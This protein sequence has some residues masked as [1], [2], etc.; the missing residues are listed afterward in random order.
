LPSV[1]ADNPLR[2]IFIAGTDTGVGKTH[3]ACALLR[4]ARNLGH[5]P[6][7][8]KP[9][10]TGA[11]PTPDDADRL[12]EAAGPS[13]PRGE[14]CLYPLPL[15]AAPQAAAEAASVTISA[16][17]ILAHAHR[18]ATAGDSLV[19]EAAGGLLVPYHPTLTGADLARLLGLPVLLVARTSLG[20]V[21]HTALTVN[22]I[23]RRG[24]D[25]LGIILC[26][27][28]PAAMPH[29]HSNIPLIR[30]LTGIAPLGVLPYVT[31]PTP[32]TLAKALAENLPPA[33]LAQL[34]RP[35]RAPAS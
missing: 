23:R 12:F 32:D 2:G 19:V 34:L 4:H 10:E 18:L 26:Q 24:L 29:E 13:V 1:L 5:R 25:L 31:T 9:A 16:D 33:A 30:Q 14:I 20:T 15:P 17:R 11:D 8:F 3:V 28:T 22:E 7:P 27:T 6:V 35:L 21:N